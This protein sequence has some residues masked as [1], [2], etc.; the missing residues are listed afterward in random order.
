M[1]KGNRQNFLTREETIA[2][3]M[4]NLEELPAA[5]EEIFKRW[6]KYNCTTTGKIGNYFFSRYSRLSVIGTSK[7]KENLV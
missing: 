3:V 5:T 2:A 6:E 1:F 7:R 4:E